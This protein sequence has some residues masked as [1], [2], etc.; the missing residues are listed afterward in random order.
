MTELGCAWDGLIRA[1]HAAG[2]DFWTM[3]GALGSA[4]SAVAAILALIFAAVAAR[5]AI[6][7]L[8]AL[9]QDPTWCRGRGRGSARSRF[10]NAAGVGWE[11]DGFGRLTESTGHLWSGIP[12][13]QPPPPPPDRDGAAAGRNRPGAPA[14]RAP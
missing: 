1:I 12:R 13:E 9:R 3:V 5:A 14:S 10:V 7:Q 6:G 4:L 11:H 8:V 2:A